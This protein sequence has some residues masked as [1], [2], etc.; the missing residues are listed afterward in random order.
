MNKDDVKVEYELYSFFDDI[1]IPTFLVVSGSLFAVEQLLSHPFEVLR[2]QFQ[3]N[4]TVSREFNPP[5]RKYLIIFEDFI[6]RFI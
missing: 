4:R 6:L 5:N 3:A 1:H 2:T